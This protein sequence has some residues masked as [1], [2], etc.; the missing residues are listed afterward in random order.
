[1]Y[2]YSPM[3]ASR[4]QFQCLA[5]VEN[6]LGLHARPAAEIA[7]FIKSLEGVSVKLRCGESEAE[8]D[9]ILQI[10]FLCAQQGAEVQIIAT[11][12]NA[13]EA[14]QGVRDIIQGQA[15]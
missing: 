4:D 15:G 8:G 9:S 12:K 1:V 14:A 2:G 7:T 13:R 10:L 3:H 5:K 6:P 11:G